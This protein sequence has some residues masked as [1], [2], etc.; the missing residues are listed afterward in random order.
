M[1]SLC[2]ILDKPYTTLVPTYLLSDDRKG[3]HTCYNQCQIK[4][5]TAGGRWL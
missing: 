3:A 1:L 2:H 4:M 5:G